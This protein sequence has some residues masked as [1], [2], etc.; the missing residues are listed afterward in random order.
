MFQ[1]TFFYSCTEIRN[2]SDHSYYLVMEYDP[3]V[4]CG[5]SRYYQM[6]VPALLSLCIF[7]IL[8]ILLV[9]F[10]P[11][12]VFRKCLFKCKLDS[13]SLAAFTDKFYS[14]YRDGL[15][16]ER[17]MRSFAGFYFLLR[18][19]P[20]FYYILHLQYTFMTL[21]IY[22]VFIF[23]SSAVLI[24]L[25]QPYKKTY[26]NVLDILLLALLAYT[27][28]V[29]SQRTLSTGMETHLSIIFS[30]PLAFV[31]VLLSMKLCRWLSRVVTAKCLSCRNYSL[32]EP[33]DQLQPL[34]A[35]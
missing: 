7:N 11:I 16:G 28:V 35:N 10:Y 27:C 14:C 23:L 18:Y 31:L 5:S 29:L 8:P 1:T 26:M 25:V 17:D 9:V 2:I 6:A 4:S 13:L 21:W 12:K 30:I 32:S 3:T 22:C 15:N 24:A 20:F 33:D 19:L 34:L